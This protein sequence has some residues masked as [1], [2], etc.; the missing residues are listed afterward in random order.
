MSAILNTNGGNGRVS[1]ALLE[2]SR[3][4]YINGP[5]TDDMAFHFNT[6]FLRIQKL[7]PLT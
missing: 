4:I 5:V 2:G 7:P 1:I 6:M 3:I